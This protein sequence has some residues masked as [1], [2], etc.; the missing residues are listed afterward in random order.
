MYPCNRPYRL[1]TFH[2][3]A[4]FSCQ[5]L[6][7]V[8]CL[9]GLKMTLFLGLKADFQSSHEAPPQCLHIFKINSSA[10]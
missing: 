5:I 10:L 6:T 4:S 7:H 1:F 2:P 8:L 9:V 3:M